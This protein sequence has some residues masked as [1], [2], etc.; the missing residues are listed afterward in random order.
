M[1]Q[2]D[3]PRFAAVPDLSG[4]V[5]SGLDSKDLFKVQNSGASAVHLRELALSKGFLGS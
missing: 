3:G 2:G 5:L 1:Q 4:F